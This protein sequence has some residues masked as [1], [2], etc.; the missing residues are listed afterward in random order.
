M[1]IDR[2]DAPGISPEDVAEAHNLDLAAQGHDVRYHTYWF[3]PANETVFCLVEGPSKQAVESVHARSHGLVAGTI[4]EIG[5]DTPMSAFFGSLPSHPPGM[6]YTAPAVRAIVFTDMC[7]SVA[8]TY[9]L[10]DEGHMQLL[11]EHDELV[12]AGLAAHDGR[13]VKHTGDGI[14]AAFTSVAA[15]VAFAVTA[16]RSL[17][18]RNRNADTPLHVKV[19]ISAGEP[20][21][22]SNDDL[23]GAAVQLAARLCAAAAA[24][25]IAVSVAVRELCMGKSFH[26]EDRGFVALKGLPEPIQ[27]YRVTWDDSGR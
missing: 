20:V 5:P 21:T 6:P 10:G 4:I 19:G 16:Q 12:R 25:D 17:V 27:T 2:H 15:A 18:E 1:Y 11:R 24:G 14:M 8:Q 26:F 23:F 22:D 3:D 13:E 7:G 9:D